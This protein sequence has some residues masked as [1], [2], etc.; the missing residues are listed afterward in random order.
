VRSGFSRVRRFLFRF[1]LLLAAAYV[2]WD[3]IEARRFSSDVAAIAARGEPVHYDAAFSQPATPEQREA[4][5]LYARAA[6]AAR[7]RAAEDNNRASRLDVDKPGG[8]EIPFEEIRAGYR[9]DDPAMQLLDRATPR[10]FAGFPADESPRDYD[11]TSLGSQACLRADVASA[12]GDGETAAAA[13]VPCIR[14]QRVFRGGFDRS[15]HGERIVGSLRIFF[16]H[17][18]PSDPALQSIQRAL[19][20]WP[21][22]DP[23]V[24]NILLGRARFVDFSGRPV[25]PGV[26]ATVGW[27]VLHPFVVR[28]ARRAL[29]AYGP[30]LARAREPWPARWQALD[31]VGRQESLQRRLRPD[32]DWRTMLLDPFSLFVPSNGFNLRSSATELAARR[33]AATAIAAERYRRAHAG[34]PPPSLAALVPGFL[35]RVPEDPYSA[36]PLVLRPAAGGYTIYSLDLNRRDDGGILYGFGA[37][38]AKHVGP[39]TPRDLGIHVPLMSRGL[40]D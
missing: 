35:P 20:S 31:E 28:S 37:A 15:R 1:L 7:D 17:T 12:S 39:A 5:M 8:P 11:V 32:S 9:G 25:F 4:A 6:Q 19:E 18:T 23:T 34:T 24:R 21:E 2:A 33:L 29:N 26:V 3:R 22:E 16:R 13:L 36:Q 40:R 30:A 10:D 14:L 27:Y 38:Q